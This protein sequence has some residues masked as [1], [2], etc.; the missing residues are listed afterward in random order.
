MWIHPGSTVILRTKGEVFN[1]I[2]ELMKTGREFAVATIVSASK[3]TPRKSGTRMIIFPDGSTE[4][5]IGGGQLE[6]TAIKKG[7]KA[8]KDD[9]EIN[10][11]VELK[12]GKSGMACG[13]EVEVLVEVFKTTLRVIIFGGGH[14]GLALSRILDVIGMPYIVVDDRRDFVTSERFPNA[15][16]VRLSAYDKVVRDLRVDEN[17]YCVIVTHSHRG[18]K[19]VL[20]DLLKT[21]AIYLGMIG[22]KNKVKTVLYSIGKEGIKVDTERIYAPIGLDIGGDAPEEIAIAIAAEILKVRY[23]K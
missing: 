16:K 2:A 9:K 21:P 1:R 8:I 3:G 10:F 14:I 12:T 18:D 17:T 11:K 19:R 4:F 6:R 13:G 15:T 20:G 5:T 22:S 23:K 7:I